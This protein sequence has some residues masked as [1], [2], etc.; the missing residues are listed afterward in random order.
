M[1]LA[2]SD[3][4]AQQ[5][6]VPTLKEKEFPECQGLGSLMGL[7]APRNLPKPIQD[8]I[9]NATRKVIQTPSVKKALEDAGY[10]VEYHGPDE[11]TK[12]FEDDYKSF[13]KIAKA[14]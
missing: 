1:F 7:V 10:T 9:N 13:D 14:A 3:K 12:K 2:T 4:L 8:Q 11:L 6:Q 5:P